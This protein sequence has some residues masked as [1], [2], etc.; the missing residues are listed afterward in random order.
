MINYIFTIGMSV[1][2]NERELANAM[3]E[4]YGGGPNTFSIELTNGRFATITPANEDIKQAIENSTVFSLRYCVTDSNGDVVASN[5]ANS[6]NNYENALAL[7]A[8]FGT[9]VEVID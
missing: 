4:A 5:F 9:K 7:L 8:E 6:Q 1:L 3:A 2:A